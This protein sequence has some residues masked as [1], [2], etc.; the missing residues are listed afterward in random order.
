M[1]HVACGMCAWCIVRAA[2]LHQPR[3]EL[4]RR[5]LRR[6]MPHH[7]RQQ[8]S[9]ARLAR[10]HALAFALALARGAA[11][12]RRRS[13]RRGFRLHRALEGVSPRLCMGMGMGM[14]M[15]MG[16]GVDMGVGSM[17]MGMGMGMGVGMG[18]GMGMGMGMG[19]GVW[20]WAWAQSTCS[21]WQP[22]RL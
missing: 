11:A 13:A 19:M 14:G 20:A 10:S 21:W 12:Y 18:V 22:C 7:L 4:A 3:L 17:G 5:P 9:V 6:D 15:S 16:M 2:R 1:W 8:R